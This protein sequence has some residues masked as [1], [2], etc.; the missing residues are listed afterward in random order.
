MKITLHKSDTF[1]AL[2]G[3]LCL[4][5][6]IA[7][8]LLFI[9]Q[10]YSAGNHESAPIW[11]Q[12]IDYLFLILSFFAVYRS[13]QTTSK[14]FM[15]PALW[16]NWVILC[17]LIINEKQEWFHLEEFFTYGAS[18]LLVGLHIYNLKFCQCSDDK[19]CH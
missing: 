11:W 3:I 7:T 16:I 15:K 4:I 10:S 6:C 18:L 17:S 19:C 14:N 2:A 5:H 9:T 12:N 1:G 8:P 13:T